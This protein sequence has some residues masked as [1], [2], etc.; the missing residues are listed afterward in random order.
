MM[1]A[2]FSSISIISAQA[3]DDLFKD[4][5]FSGHADLYYQFDFNK[6]G[7]RTDLAWRQFD[8]KHD[9]FALAALQFNISKAPKEGSPFGFTLSVAAGKNQDIIHAAEPGGK[10]TYKY[11]QQAYVTYAVSKTGATVDIGKFLTWIGLEGIVT[12][13]NDLYSLS[14]VFFV[15]QPIYHMGVRATSPLGKG[16]TGGLYLVN[17]WN[18]VEDSNGAKSYGASLSGT[19][20]SKTNVSLNY[21]GGVEGA[22]T[23]NGFF[24][25]PAG[26]TSVHLGDLVLTHQLTPNIKLAVNA[27]YGTSKAVD[28]GD[29]SGNFRGI[30]AYVRDQVSSKVGVAL[31]Y[32]TVSDPDGLR[33]G[34]NT[35]LGSLTAM[36]EYA[37]NPNA[38]FRLELRAD[39]SNRD[40]FASDSGAKNKR[41][42]LTLAHLIKF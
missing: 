18:E 28:P 37:V 15:C 8:V 34:G 40:L 5:T 4:V 13:G 9:Q 35:R 17:G 36:V 14:N 2:I 11:I 29:P 39:N 42:T 3:A 20:G 31:R 27:D 26:Q 16:V 30:A 22:S 1:L 32:D 7:S 41:T 25:A 19:V 33:T 6:P 24:G 21:Y 10:D 38:L 12:P 23:I